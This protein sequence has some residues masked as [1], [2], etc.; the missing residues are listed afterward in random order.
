V[1]TARGRPAAEAGPLTPNA[2]P[3]NMRASANHTAPLVRVWSPGLGPTLSLPL[4]AQP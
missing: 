2:S 3:V 1:V 4:L